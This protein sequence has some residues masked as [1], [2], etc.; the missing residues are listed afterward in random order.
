LPLAAWNVSAVASVKR[1]QNEDQSKE[2]TEPATKLQKVGAV[3][4][5]EI[6]QMT[7]WDEDED[8]DF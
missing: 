2:R 3:E 7:L 1:P 6:D 5:M 8:L 4:T